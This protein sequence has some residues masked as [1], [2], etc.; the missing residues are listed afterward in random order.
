[1]KSVKMAFENT[2]KNMKMTYFYWYVR[3]SNIY[4][5]RTK[6]FYAILCHFHATTGS[7]LLDCVYV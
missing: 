7:M 1:M 2:D 5:Q 4:L 3:E 6:G